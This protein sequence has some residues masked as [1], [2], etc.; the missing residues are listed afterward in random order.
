MQT[1]R[2]YVQA[3]Q[4]IVENYIPELLRDDVPQALRGKRNIIFG[5]IEKIY[6]F[7]RQYFLRELEACERN[8]F[9][10]GHYFLLH[11]SVL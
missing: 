6:Q 7:H 9:Q 1:E 10:V 3:L 8:P 11:V 5:N 2:D 4:F